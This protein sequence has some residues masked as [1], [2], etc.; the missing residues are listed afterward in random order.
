MYIERE[1]KKYQLTAEE[2]LEANAEF[3]TNWMK[4]TLEAD[5]GIPENFSQEYAEW[6]YNR[7]SEGNG[8]TE[9]KCIELAAKEYERFQKLILGF[10]KP[11]VPSATVV[12]QDT[13]TDS[14]GL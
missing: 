11:P 8:E 2:L 12:I 10:R 5:F 4:T 14:R 6:A 13:V 9:Y 1:G 7:Y 3:V